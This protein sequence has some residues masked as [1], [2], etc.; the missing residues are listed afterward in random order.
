MSE[1]R[2]LQLALVVALMIWAISALPSFACEPDS[3]TAGK[4]LKC[5]NPLPRTPQPTI[6][7]VASPTPSPTA[8]PTP[9]PT[10]T[11][12]A[13][14]TAQPTAPPTARPTQSTSVGPNTIAALGNPPS[15]I[16]PV[17]ISAADYLNNPA[18]FLPTDASATNALGI[19]ERCPPPFLPPRVAPPRPTVAPS[20]SPTRANANQPKGDSPFTAREM[21]GEWQTLAGNSQLWYRINNENNFYLNVWMDTYARPGIGFAVFSPEQAQNLNA[22]TPPK[23][24]GAQQVSDRTHDLWWNGAQAPGIWHV[25]VTNTTPDPLQ[26]RIGYKPAT[27]ERNC[28]SYWEYLPTGAYV[29][30]TACR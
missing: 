25:L 23:G 16:N 19:V 4:D 14:P 3:D 8:S 27:E 21:T 13:T 20:P 5:R 17:L 11:P 30:W 29:Y 6:L 12:T 26:Y 24:R 22:V 10:A 1:K 2:I 9:Q 15:A 18:C 28:R 7:P